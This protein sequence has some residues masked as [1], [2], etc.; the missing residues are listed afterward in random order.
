MK[1]IDWLIAA[2]LIGFVIAGYAGYWWTALNGLVG[3]TLLASF[4]FFDWRAASQPTGVSGELNLN[5]P[6]HNPAHAACHS[7][8]DYSDSGGGE[9]GD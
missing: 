9:S 1:I 2:M 5:L 8:S 4:R 3:T 7:H 6:T